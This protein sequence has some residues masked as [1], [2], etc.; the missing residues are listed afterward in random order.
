MMP[1]TFEDLLQDQTE[2]QFCKETAERAGQPGSQ[3]DR[4]CYRLFVPKLALAWVLQT[5]VPQRLKAR[6][7]YLAHYP[8]VSGSPGGFRMYYTPPGRVLAAQGRRRIL[9]I[10]G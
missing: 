4:D 1:I 6:F 7:M 9:H 10:A 5:F 8:Q 2:D 3:Y